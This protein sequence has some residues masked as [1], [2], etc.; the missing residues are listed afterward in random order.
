M[1]N[2][3]NMQESNL[4]N[5]RLGEAKRHHDLSSIFD[6]YFLETHAFFLGKNNVLRGNSRKLVFAAT[7]IQ[8]NAKTGDYYWSGWN[9]E[10]LRNVFRLSL[11]YANTSHVVELKE[12]AIK[13]H[14]NIERLSPKN[15]IL[16]SIDN[17]TYPTVFLRLD[18]ILN[19]YVL[20]AP[21]SISRVA[22]KGLYLSFLS[23]E[24]HLFYTPYLIF[25]YWFARRSGKFL[26]FY[27]LG[28][29]F[30]LKFLNIKATII[31][32]SLFYKKVKKIGILGTKAEINNIVKKW[33]NS[34]LGSYRRKLSDKHKYFYRRRL[35]RIL[36]IK[37]TLPKFLNIRNSIEW[38]NPLAVAKFEMFFPVLTK[39]ILLSFAFKLLKESYRSGF[40]RKRK[41]NIRREFKKKLIGLYK[42]IRLNEPIEASADLVKK[43]PKIFLTKKIFN[44]ITNIE[45]RHNRIFRNYYNVL[46]R[47]V[48]NYV[49]YLE[50]KKRREAKKFR[51]KAANIF[52]QNNTD[53]VKRKLYKRS[54]YF[55]FIKK[56]RKKH[57]ISAYLE[58]K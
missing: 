7:T 28:F 49:L 11:K 53:F 16:K 30:N 27:H 18:T 4:N 51:R 46:K 22:N 35:R 19:K 44:R 13:R 24:L 17:V 45:K 40:R 10:K 57:E 34:I 43:I 5:F 20:R 8:Y 38:S 47:K 31:S 25:S 23:R 21:M 54:D 50:R 1:V 48:I 6:K 15:L 42:K 37:L 52:K 26:K 58:K 41:K 56:N 14:R 39:D 9:G 32:L 3:Y 2:I 12:T 29:N 36:P 55:K 33:N